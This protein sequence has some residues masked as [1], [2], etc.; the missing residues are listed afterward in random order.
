MPQDVYDFLG[1]DGA[2]LRAD[3]QHLSTAQTVII[4]VGANQND[5]SLQVQPLLFPLLSGTVLEFSGGGLPSPQT[6]TILSATAT[7]GSTTLAVVPLVAA[8]PPL[9][10]AR[11]DGVNLIHAQ[12][13]VKACQFGTSQVKFYCSRR[14]DDEDMQINANGNGSVKRWATTLASKWLCSRRGMAPPEGIEQL[15]DEA[16]DEMK[17]VLS[18]AAQ[19]ED[20]GTRTSSAPFISNMTMNIGYDYRKLRVESTMSEG[21]PTQFPQAID[22]N[23]A[24]WVEF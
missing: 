21:T 18:G 12:R 19:I 3:D 24:L 14:Y 5:A 15:A 8:L 10:Q 17:M 4:T 7:R 23:S 2:Q 22:W 6:D 20:I 1:N 9:A 11:D 13:L 16:I